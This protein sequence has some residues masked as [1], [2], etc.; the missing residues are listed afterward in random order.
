MSAQLLPLSPPA[1]LDSHHIVQGFDSGEPSL[2]SWLA[3]WA[4]A[5]Q[6]SGASRT[7]VACR[8]DRVVAYYAL[9]AGAIAS[10]EAPGRLKRNMPD[11][12]PVFVLGRLAVDRSEQGR[13]LGASMLRDAVLQTCRAAQHGGITGLLVHAISEEAKRFY[14]RWG[15][16]ESPA[17]PLTLVATMKD[18]NALIE[19]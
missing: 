19:G 2:D 17:N 15:F 9:A 14:L 13:K 16:V 1:P 18:L 3:R 4:L 11:P 10:N 6:A 12:I 8:G 5:N 7:F